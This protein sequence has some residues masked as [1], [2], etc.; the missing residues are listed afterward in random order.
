MLHPIEIKSAQTYSLALYT[1]L[2]KFV[3]LEPEAA[4]PTLVYGG[5]KMGTLRGGRVLSFAQTAQIVAN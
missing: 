3:A 2:L 4:A 5:E 1:N